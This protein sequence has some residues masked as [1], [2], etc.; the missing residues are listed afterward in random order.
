MLYRSGGIS[1]E[2]AGDG[3]CNSDE[4]GAGIAYAGGGG[5]ATAAQVWPSIV[6]PALHARAEAV[7]QDDPGQR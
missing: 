5:I 7:S 1:D 4:C 2:T 6:T 3:A